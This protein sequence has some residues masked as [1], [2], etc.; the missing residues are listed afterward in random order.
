MIWEYGVQIDNETDVGNKIYVTKRPNIPAPE[1]RFEEK[2]IPG[3]DGTLTIYDGSIEDISI[4]IEFNFMG[5]PEEWFEIFRKAKKWLLK[6]GERTLSFGDDPAFYYIIKR[7]RI[8]TAERVC[9]EIGKFTAEFICKGTHFFCS[10]KREI[11]HKK[12]LDNPGIFSL[13]IY[14]IT[15]E[16]TCTLTVNGKS[17]TA[18][19]AQNLTIDTERMISY[20]EDGT[21]QN[22]AISG[23]YGDLYFQE[24]KNTIT[25]TEGFECKVIPRWRCL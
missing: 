2:R 23:D 20:R 1:Q 15:G 17:V 16:G 25:V 21:L 6:K 5:K 11:D 19:V 4:F 24:G 9:Y 3:R 10:G 18:N 7:A 22:T 8:E 13:P 14:I 12:L